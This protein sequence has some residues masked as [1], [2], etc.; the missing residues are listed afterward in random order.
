M[1]TEAEKVKTIADWLGTGSINIFGA[2]F[3]GKDTQGNWLARQLDTPLVGGGDILRNNKNIPDY[4]REVMNQGKLAPIQEYLNIVTPYLSQKIFAGKPLILSAVGR[5]HGEEM[6][7][8]EAAKK[9]GHP[10]KVVI[11]LSISETEV[12]KRW[13]K[14]PNKVDR[15]GRHDDHGEIIK[16]RLD[17][18]RTKTLPVI[19]FYRQK[20]LL[21]E[22]DGSLSPDEVSHQ[23]YAGLYK[24]ATSDNH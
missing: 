18:F 1:A 16:I 5:W 2:P 9:A 3:A 4:V 7:I 15:V 24:K 8:T 11:L 22:V 23:I 21:L 13:Q 17:E 12:M 20:G 6:V 14:L 10:I 19:D